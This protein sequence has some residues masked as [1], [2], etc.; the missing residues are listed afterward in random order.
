MYLYI[1]FFGGQHHE[2]IYFHHARAD[3]CFVSDRLRWDIVVV[4]DHRVCSRVYGTIFRLL[5][6]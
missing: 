2:K 4:A 3:S 5:S 6:Y 1:I